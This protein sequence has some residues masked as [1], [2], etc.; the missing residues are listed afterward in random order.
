VV[1]DFGIKYENEEDTQHLIESLTPHYKIT[2]DR[3]GARFIRL[4]LEWD[5]VNREL[6]VSMP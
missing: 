1:D 3:E 4:T 2:T 5:Y 6:H